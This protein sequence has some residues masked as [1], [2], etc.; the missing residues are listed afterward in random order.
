MGAPYGADQARSVVSARPPTSTLR[1]GAVMALAC[2][3]SND[4]DHEIAAQLRRVLPGDG[5]EVSS[6]RRQLLDVIETNAAEVFAYREVDDD[7][8]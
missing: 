3:V 1:K 8:D 6:F 5:G 2:F 7:L 4:A